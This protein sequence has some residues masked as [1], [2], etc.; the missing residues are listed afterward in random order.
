MERIVEAVPLV[1]LEHHVLR[2][3]SWKE[4]IKHIYDLSSNS[5]HSVVTAAEYS[6]NENLFL[7]SERKQLYSNLPPS[8]EFKQWMKTLNNKTIAKP[9]I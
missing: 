4:K 7:E 2:D 3:E 1:I 8:A 5:G 6:G 9:P